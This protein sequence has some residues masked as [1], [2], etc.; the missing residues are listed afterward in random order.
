MVYTTSGSACDFNTLYMV[1][2]L[3]IIIPNKPI[4]GPLVYRYGYFK[5]AV[6]VPLQAKY[7]GVV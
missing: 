2:N 7:G 3:V 5:R 6:R 4:V 1:Y